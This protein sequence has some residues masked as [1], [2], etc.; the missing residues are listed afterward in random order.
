MMDSLSKIAAPAARELQRVEEL[1]EETLSSTSEALREIERHSIAAKGKCIRPAMTLLAGAAGGPL[2][3]KNVQ[4]AAASEL[5]HMATLVHDDVID[6]A[7]LRRGRAALHVSWSSPVAVLF[8]DYLLS[9]AFMILCRFRENGVLPAMARMTR[10]VCEGEICQLR[11][12]LDTTMT[13]DEYLEMVAL[14]T[15]SIFSTC[16]GLSASLSGASPAAAAALQNFGAGFGTA[17]QVVDDCLDLT[18]HGEDKDNLKDI[19]GGRVTL[20]LIKALAS[21]DGGERERLA[22]AFRAADT[23]RCREIILSTGAVEASLGAAGRLMDR[24]RGELSALP[25]SPAA[26]SLALCAEYVIARGSR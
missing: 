26:R 14:K 13:E 18:G 16:C 19:E 7:R 11:R 15:A 6:G 22:D 1:L 4:L 17:Y 9:H 25:D 21:L 20:P 12:R 23:G 24:A 5:I 2:T 8:G 3:E 10:E